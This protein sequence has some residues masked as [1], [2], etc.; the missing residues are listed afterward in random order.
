MGLF[1]QQISQLY[2][3]ISS[4]NGQNPNDKAPLASIKIYNALLGSAKTRLPKD[5]VIASLEEASHPML[6]RNLLAQIGQLKALSDSIQFN[7]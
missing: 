6:V 7:D 1:N 5:P 2:K 3:D 4:L